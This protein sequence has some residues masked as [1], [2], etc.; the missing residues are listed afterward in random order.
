MLDFFRDRL[1]AE[2]ILDL[3]EHLPRTSAYHCAVAED[4]GLAREIAKSPNLPKPSKTPPLQEWTPEVE[5]LRDVQDILDQTLRVLVKVNNGKPGKHKPYPRPV[6]A[7]A[8]A[9]R[10]AR[11]KL[12]YDQHRSVVDRVLRRD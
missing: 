7:L 8:R 10:S 4:E 6:T 3:L 12:R 1:S 9:L 5:A 2:E 11:Q